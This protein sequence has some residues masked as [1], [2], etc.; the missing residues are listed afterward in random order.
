MNATLET[1]ATVA[2]PNEELLARKISLFRLV[3]VKTTSTELTI[4]QLINGI[5]T[6]IWKNEVEE[7]RETFKIL[8]KPAYKEARSKLLECVTISGTFN[9]CSDE[10][11]E[12]HSGL[13]AIDLDD[14]GDNLAATKQQ[15]MNDSTVFC[16]FVS[17]SGNG[18][19]VLHPIDAKDGA[20]HRAAY[21]QILERYE[22]LGLKPDTT[23]IN[24]SRLCFVSYDPEIWV[25][26]SPPPLLLSTPLSTPTSTPT[27]YNLPSTSYILHTTLQ[28]APDLT[29]SIRRL[30]LLKQLEK[31]DPITAELYDNHVIRRY[32]P[33][34]G[35][36]NE[37]LSQLVPYWFRAISGEV[38]EKLATIDLEMNRG[39]YDGTIE[40]H[41]RSLKGLWD[42][43]KERYPSELSEAELS[44][45][46]LLNP[47]EQTAFRIMRDLAK[48]HKGEPFFMSCDQLQNRISRRCNGQRLRDMLRFHGIIKLI[49]LGQ[50]REK[51][52]R[53]RA[54]Y[55]KWMLPLPIA[56]PEKIAAA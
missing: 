7:L 12:C 35:K 30:K 27:I 15:L 19:K 29:D 18:L 22:A 46:Q 3:T 10:G 53:G 24:P 36:R 20:T 26:P 37:A 52:V 28:P 45:Y 51:G 23:G 1:T 17:P 48:F 32:T 42:G 44:F 49:T 5:K 38:A 21:Q 14:L 4:A 39:L 2:V 13:I 55:W 54:A 11:L 40:E 56:E 31:N 25:N 41:L 16:F 8:G 6:G 9:R 34:A 33:E 50:R 47:D 43:C